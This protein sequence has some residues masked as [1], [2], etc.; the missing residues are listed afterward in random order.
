[1][2]LNNKMAKKS[3]TS[4]GKVATWYDNLLSMDD[5]YQKEVILPNLLRLVDPQKSDQILDLACGQGFFA[6]ALAANGGELVGVDIAAELVKLAVQSA[7]KNEKFFVSSADDLSK[8]ASD[9]FNKVLIVLALQNIENL[10]QV[11]AEVARV[12]KKD[13]KFFIVLNHPAFRNPKKTSW[14]FDDENKV[15]FRRVDEYLSE[16]RTEID[17][18]PG[19]KNNKITTVSFHRPLQLYI[20]NLAKNNFMISRLEEWISHRSSEKGPRQKAEDKARK[21]IPLFLFLEATK[22]K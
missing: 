19:S 11:I 20:K 15:Q 21:E 10:N 7:A 12:L 4:W 8:F 13:G 3:E 2:S 18:K 17:M 1:M 22:I 16:S 14:G 5:T 9:S 6:H